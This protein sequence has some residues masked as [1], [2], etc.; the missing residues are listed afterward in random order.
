MSLGYSYS[1]RIPASKS[2]LNRALI[3]Q[4]YFHELKIIGESECED[5]MNL[6]N[7]LLK[8]SEGESELFAGDGGT[9][10]RFLALRVSRKTGEYRIQGTKRLMERPQAE[11]VAVLTQLG[12][13]ARLN[14]S[15]LHIRS[16]GWRPSSVL[17]VSGS[18]S[19]QFLSSV[20]LNLWNLES[21]ILIR[22]PKALVSEPYLMMTLKMLSGLGLKLQDRKDHWQVEPRQIAKTNRLHC[23]IDLSSAFSIAA[24]AAIGG[25]AIF[26]DYPVHSTQ[27]DATFVSILQ[28]MN[29]R[30]NIFIAKEGSHSLSVTN[31]PLKSIEVDLNKMPDLFPVLAVLCCFADGKSQLRG[32]SQLRHKESDRIRSTARLL[33][34]IQVKFEEHEDGLVIFGEP[35]L[36]A[37]LSL[38]PKFEFD[39]D[40]DHRLAMAAA[41]VKKAGASL[42]IL[43]PEV[44]NKSF[45]E[46]WRI[47]K[48]NP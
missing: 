19:S 30:C 4:S 47:A 36:M 32:A 5:V 3:A 24:I 21:E 48:V 44:V 28:K 37:R 16:E 6:K 25:H 12:V 14:G 42:Q 33:E 8:F 22:K 10:L 27:A 13:Q 23:E 39:P 35:E 45:P 20:F 9:T 18:E 1:G 15:Y 29:V 46:F 26:E 7:S 43:N 38:L 2:I 34:S 17:N 31:G 11:L 40:H 41:I